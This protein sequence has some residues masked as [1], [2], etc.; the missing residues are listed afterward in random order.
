MKDQLLPILAMICTVVATL[1]MLVFC[2]AMGAN[3]KPEEIQ[4]LKGWMIGLSLLGLAGIAVG[5]L[6][7]RSAQPGLA[8]GVSLLPAIVMGILFLVSILK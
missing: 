2:M 5:I 1:V 7:M 8:A 6:L 3:A 4:A